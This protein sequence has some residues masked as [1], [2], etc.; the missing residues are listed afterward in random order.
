LYHARGRYGD[1]EP[2]YKRSLGILEKTL[3]PEHPD[4][5]QI[6]DNCA[7]LLRKIGRDSEAARMETR[8]KI[9]RTKHPEWMAQKKVVFL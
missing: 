2:L 3:R 8:A 4:V 9:M 1:A 7:V 5:A 6:L